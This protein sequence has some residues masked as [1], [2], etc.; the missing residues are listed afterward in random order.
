MSRNFFKNLTSL[1]H[2][3]FDA[4]VSNAESIFEGKHR[5]FQVT[6]V[7]FEWQ[8]CFEVRVQLNI[9]DSKLFQV[10]EFF[11]HEGSSHLKSDWYLKSWRNYKTDCIVSIPDFFWIFD[12][13]DLKHLSLTLFIFLF[14]WDNLGSLFDIP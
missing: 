9:K 11:L 14:L 3:F 6:L 7:C 12:R 1:Q 4:F 5:S 8:R 10:M 2:K 13:S